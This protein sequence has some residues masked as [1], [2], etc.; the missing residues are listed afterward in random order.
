MQF[1]L[2]ATKPDDNRGTSY[3]ADH[4]QK[5]KG[6][7]PVRPSPAASRSTLSHPEAFSGSA[8]RAATHPARDA[9]RSARASHPRFQGSHDMAILA[10]LSAASADCRPQPIS[11]SLPL[12][13]PLPPR[14]S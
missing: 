11:Y 6:P 8:P 2:H 4:L 3:S 7:H 14:S 13:N 1:E 12:I 10:E 9:W 5:D